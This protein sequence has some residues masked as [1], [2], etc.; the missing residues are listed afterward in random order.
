MSSKPVTDWTREDVQIWL[1]HNGFSKYAEVFAVEHEIDGKA[2]LTLREEDLKLMNITKIGDVKRLSISIKQL[3]RD[4]IATLFDLG[5]LDLYST[6][7][8]YSH[9]RHDVRIQFSF[10][11][12]KRNQTYLEKQLNNINHFTQLNVCQDFNRQSM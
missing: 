11:P 8:F 2:L 12:N 3:Q 6:S 7:S 10:L 5:H 1:V 9:Q 4:N